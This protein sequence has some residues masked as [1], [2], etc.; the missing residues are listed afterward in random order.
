MSDLTGVVFELIRLIA[1]NNQR[2]KLFLT[3]SFNQKD[4]VHFTA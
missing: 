2:L 3:N 1:F 4:R